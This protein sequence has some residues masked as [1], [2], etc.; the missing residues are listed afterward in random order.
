LVDFSPNLFVNRFD[1]QKARIKKTANLEFGTKPPKKSIFLAKTHKSSQSSNR[2]ATL[3]TFF[4]K[5]PLNPPKSTH[6]R[7]SAEFGALFASVWIW[8][9]W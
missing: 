7:Y 6:I 5:L 1:C 2:K 4:R 9:E 3:A 8:R